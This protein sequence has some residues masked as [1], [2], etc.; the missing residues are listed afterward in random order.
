M[1]STDLVKILG[2]VPEGTEIKFFDGEGAEL[3]TRSIGLSVTLSDTGDPEFESVD[4]S[5]E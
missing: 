5:F 4:I 1:T 3:S 2:K